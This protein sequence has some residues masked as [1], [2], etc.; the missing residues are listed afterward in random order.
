MKR[1]ALG[2]ICH[3]PISGLARLAMIARDGNVFPFRH[4]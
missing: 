1:G 2:L 3:N 4:G